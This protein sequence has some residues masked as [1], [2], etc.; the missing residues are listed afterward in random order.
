MCRL[1]GLHAGAAAVSA[2]FWLLDAPDSLAAQSRRNPDGAGVGVF[3]PDGPPQVSK[4]PIAAWDDTDFASAARELTGTTFVAHVRHASTGADT[5]ANTHPFEQAGRLFAHNGVVQGLDHLDARL[6]ELGVF[7][8]VLGETDSE[9]VFALITGET[10]SH[11]GDVT[12][13]LAAAIGWIGEHLPIYSVNMVLVTGSDLWALRYPATNELWVLQRPAGGAGDS[14]PLNARTERIH[15]RSAG[16]AAQ[17]SVVIASEPMDS[18]PGWRLLASGEL[19]RVTRDLAL[20][21]SM[22]FPSQPAHQ[23]SLSDLAPTA[24]ASQQATP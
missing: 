3:E 4:Q 7:N 12:A 17:P 16:L 20:V 22:P 11:G 24:A 14:L 9:R 13:G 10:A 23:L 19:L 2:T 1:F 18:D 15:A 21:T 5:M 8:L 6:M